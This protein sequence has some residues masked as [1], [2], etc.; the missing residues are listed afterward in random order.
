MMRSVKLSIF[1][2]LLILVPS[3][4]ADS[5]QIT[6]SSSVTEF[7]DNNGNAS[8]EGIYETKPDALGTQ[9]VVYASTPYFHNSPFPDISFSLPSGSTITS[10]TLQLLLPLTP[11]HGTATLSLDPSNHIPPPDIENPIHIAPTLNPNGV[12]SIFVDSPVLIPFISGIDN[13]NGFKVF[14][15]SSLLASDGNRLSADL[16]T[17][18]L[19][20][21]GLISTTVD[22]QGFNFAGYVG[23]SGQ[24]EIPYMLQIDGTFS[25]VPEPSGFVLLA[26]GM[27]GA[28]VIARRLQLA[29]KVS[30]RVG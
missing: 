19:L 2:F 15:L 23:G 30:G 27:A 8:F 10:A 26:T 13:G 21:G 5:F 28:V 9:T 1:I 7:I 6:I 24:A 3:A 18:H 29:R 4:L 17:L 22:V 20:V 16:E 12:S 11:V 14:D 25:T